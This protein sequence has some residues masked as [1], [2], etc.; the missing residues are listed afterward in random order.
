MDVTVVH[1][2][3]HSMYLHVAGYIYNTGLAPCP[4]WDTTV[5]NMCKS[6]LQSCCGPTADAAVLQLCC[7][8]QKV[9][10]SAGI[11]RKWASHFSRNIF[12]CVFSV[13]TSSTG[14]REEKVEGTAAYQVCHVTRGRRTYV[15]RADF[16]VLMFSVFRTEQTRFEFVDVCF[17]S[18]W[19]RY[20]SWRSA[21]LY[22]ERPGRHPQ[23]S[24]EPE[25]ELEPGLPRPA[26]FVRAWPD[27]WA[28]PS[29]DSVW[30]VFS[31]SVIS[32]HSSPL[33]WI[34]W[35]EGCRVFIGLMYWLC[36]GDHQSLQQCSQT[37]LDLLD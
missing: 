16:D 24:E 8:G 9:S 11:Q 33:I 34:T 25:L 37:D 7:C 36:L 30:G 1:L 14:W 5:P 3:V 29:S 22:P 17:W 4:Y 2:C 15:P 20:P 19:H 31:Y 26:G 23:Q 21:G 13:L 12:H 18:E 10:S 27:G 28:A 35:K 32:Q 6:K